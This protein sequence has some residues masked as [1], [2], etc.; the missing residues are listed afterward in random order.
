MTV[1]QFNYTGRHLIP[2]EC[3]DANLTRMTGPPSLDVVFDF[4]FSGADHLMD[5]PPSARVY[6]DASHGMSFMRFDHGEFQSPRTPSNTLLTELDSWSSADFV[7]RIVEDGE[8]LAAS[9][10]L[11]LTRAVPDSKT[12]RSLIQPDIRDLGERPWIL[13]VHETMATPLL[14]FNEKW[15]NAALESGFPLNEQKPLMHVIMPSV[16]QGMLDWLLIHQR[17]DHHQ[18]YD[19]PTWKGAWIRYARKLVDSTP[20]TPVEDG[21]FED[22]EDVSEWISDVVSAYS[23]NLGLTSHLVHIERQT[24][25]A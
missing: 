14:V 18:L 15:W 6:V 13:E 23:E 7:V 22:V 1:R 16:L 2:Q 24:G 8:L 20:P 19:E 12:R 17:G 5:I 10:P 9:K 4:D 11:T 3:I 25:G 21:E